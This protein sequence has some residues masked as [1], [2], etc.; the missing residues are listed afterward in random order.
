MKDFISFVEKYWHDPKFKLAF[1]LFAALGT[2]LVLDSTKNPPGRPSEFGLSAIVGSLAFAYWRFAHRWPR[3]PKGRVGFALAISSEDAAHEQQIKNDLFRVLRSLVLSDSSATKLHFLAVPEFLAKQCVDKDSATLALRSMRAHIMLYGLVRK[4]ILNGKASHI[5]NLEGIVVHSSVSEETQKAL[6]TDFGAVNP[7]EVQFTL[8]NDA[9]S[10]RLTSEWVDTA[11]RYIVGLAAFVS[12][13]AEYAEEMLLSSERLF[14]ERS[15]RLK[16][17]KWFPERV[18]SKLVE[19]YAQWASVLYR[20]FFLKRELVVLEELE[21]IVLKL[22]AR[23]PNDFRA[24]GLA[25]MCA[26]LLRRDISEAKRRL[27]ACKADRDTAWRFSLGFLNAYEGNVGAALNRYRE[28]FAGNSADPTLAVQV[29][30]FIQIVLDV[31]PNK[32]QLHFFSGQINQFMKQD[33]A[34]AVRDYSAFLKHP[35]ANSFPTLQDEAE[36]HVRELSAE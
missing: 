23:S 34:A 25:A 10:F 26:F 3:T 22:L 32:G 16:H 8:D 19:L 27:T 35:T 6:A 9:L 21:P 36:K 2:F 7:R 5:I 13:D 12:S 30:E 31:E 29:E 17:L 11:A 33:R 24:L 14:K 20:Q 15:G 4:R 28:A 1:P 18:N